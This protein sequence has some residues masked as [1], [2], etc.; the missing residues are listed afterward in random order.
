MKNRRI[1]GICL[2]ALLALLL[3]AQAK[4]AG[5]IDLTRDCGLTL[6]YQD[7]G[8]PLVGASFS[9]YLVADV[10]A[11]GELT[12]AGDFAAFPV[13]IRGRNDEAWRALASTLEG[14]VLRDQLTPADSGITDLWGQLVFPTPGRTLTPGLYLV[15]G[16]RH[17]QSGMI[18][19]AQPF[20]VMLP[21]LDKEAN[22]WDYGVEVTPKHQAQP[23]PEEETVS[24][25]VLKVWRDAGHESERPREIVV[26]LL[27]DGKLYGT[28]ILNEANSWRTAWE[29]L[30][31]A[32]H[33]TV[34]EAVPEGYTVE[35]V[36]EGVTFVIVNTSQEPEDPQN[37][38][39][40]DDTDVPDDP[41]PGGPTEPDPGEHIPDGPVPEGPALPQT[42]QLWWPAP[43]LIAVG[44]LL[45]VMGLLRRRGNGK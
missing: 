2:A 36:R 4:A 19:D 26:Q 8:V 28:A 42:G 23:E 44:L 22:D 7:N 13:D 9:I 18:Y 21:A 3:P 33:W 11:S 5:S 10:D 20:M 34:V 17:R 43:L 14:Y 37:P 27:Q 45:I 41:V 38:P 40:P 31:A 6:S 12:A 16:Q 1:A 32:C 25:K 30:D 39:P 29:D 35:I 24:R 15:L